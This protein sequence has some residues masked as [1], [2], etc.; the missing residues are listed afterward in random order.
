MPRFCFSSLSTS[1]ILHENS[2]FTFLFFIL[3]FSGRRVFGPRS[4]RPNM[5]PEILFPPA[6][7]T[8]GNLQD[9]C[10]FSKAEVRYPKDMFPL[11]GFSKEYRQ[12][13]AVNR[14]QPWYGVCCGLNATQEEKI[15][16]AIQA[17]RIPT[18]LPYFIRHVKQ[19]DRT[20]YRVHL[21]CL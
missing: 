4:M 12:A 10:K 17:V 14:L 18:S 15:C 16:C 19:R 5:G 11:D 21:P 7:P 3:I 2:T 9:I 6:F 20:M 1:F 13:D 8:I